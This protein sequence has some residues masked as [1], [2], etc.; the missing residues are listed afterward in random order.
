MK[1]TVRRKPAELVSPAGPTPQELKRISE[2][3]D[4]DGLRFHVPVIYL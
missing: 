2:I 3:D 4:H 1:F